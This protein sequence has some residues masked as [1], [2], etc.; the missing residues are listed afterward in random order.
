MQLGKSPGYPYQERRASLFRRSFHH[1]QSHHCLSTTVWVLK[2]S[3]QKWFSERCLSQGT[4]RD[5]AGEGS[6]YALT[7]GPHHSVTTLWLECL[8]NETVCCWFIVNLNWSG[9]KPGQ[10]L[11]QIPR[12]PLKF[13]MVSLAVLTFTRFRSHSSH[14]LARCPEPCP[15]ILTLLRWHA[16]RCC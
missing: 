14:H 13:G 2:N 6:S 9:V 4:E 1:F 8:L 11:F 3:L 10:M 5:R 7:K 15:Q 12:R 16:A